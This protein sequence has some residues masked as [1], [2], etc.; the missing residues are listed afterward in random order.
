MLHQPPILPRSLHLELPVSN[1][2]QLTPTELLFQLKL[3]T[4][5]PPPS[6]IESPELRNKLYDA[7]EGAMVSFEDNSYP[8][9]RVAVAQVYSLRSLTPTD[10]NSTLKDVG[11]Q[12]W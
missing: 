6:L 10:D 9:S 7:A 2:S 8:I 3:Y 12:S 5:N 11:K 1:G 4:F